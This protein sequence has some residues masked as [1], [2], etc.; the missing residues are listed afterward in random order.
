MS[1]NFLKEFGQTGALNRD[2]CN[3]IQSFLI[4]ERE[5]H[6]M[7]KLLGLDY[8]WYK[9]TKCRTFGFTERADIGWKLNVSFNPKHRNQCYRCRVSLFNVGWINSSRNGVYYS[10]RIRNFVNELCKS[11]D[12]IHHYDGIGRDD[13][14]QSH[15][16][17]IK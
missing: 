7:D 10:D 6:K 16:C 3:I 2:V 14:E 13:G 11:Y 17:T 4:P 12:R 8:P 1:Y 15:P 9:C 5:K